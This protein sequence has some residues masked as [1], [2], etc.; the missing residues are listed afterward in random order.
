MKRLPVPPARLAPS[1]CVS[2]AVVLSGCAPE[3]SGAKRYEGTP[4]TSM[5]DYAAGSE[6]VINNPNGNIAVDIA[7]L[8]NQ[9]SVSGVPFAIVAD[10]A[11]DAAGQ[12]A[13]LAAMNGL[14][15]SVGPAAMGVAVD[16]IGADGTRGLDLTVHLPLFYRAA[17]T[18]RA[19]HGFVNF[20]GASAAPVTTIYAKSGDVS[21]TNIGNDLYVQGV[22]SNIVVNAAPT[23]TGGS[24]VTDD[25]D[26]I[27]K[28]PDAANLFVTATSL[29]GGTVTPPPERGVEE[30]TTSFIKPPT[31]TSQAVTTV[32][33]DGRSANIELGDPLR[34][35]KRTL[36]V[37]TGNGNV[38]FL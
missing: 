33:P 4:V 6:I 32:A 36:E 29:K 28:I 2:F 10:V 3:T 15:L 7:G 13:A 19:D 5:S 16:V 9:I 34:Q 17:V 20:V 11:D 12:Q 24:I 8:A 35:G 31:R 21:V 30:T 38:I 26:V 37:S 18:I 27:A 23:L 22:A 14:D 1:L 25:G